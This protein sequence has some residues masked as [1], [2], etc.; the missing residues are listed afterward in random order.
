MKLAQE[1]ANG[2]SPLDPK[3]STLLAKGVLQ[4]AAMMPEREVVSALNVCTTMSAKAKLMQNKGLTKEIDPL[5]EIRQWFK[6]S[7]L[8]TA[9]ETG[10][11]EAASAALADDDESEP[12]NTEVTDDRQSREEVD[13]PQGNA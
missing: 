2:M 4:R 13:R 7:V 8:V 9:V 10:D 11:N 1:L 12:T 3:F 6:D 5:S